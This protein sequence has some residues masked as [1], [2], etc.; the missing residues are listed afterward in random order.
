[1]RNV[2]KY[3]PDRDGGGGRTKNDIVADKDFA[4]RTYLIFYLH[5][6]YFK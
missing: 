6:C 2:L 4:R 3:A 1:M 5:L